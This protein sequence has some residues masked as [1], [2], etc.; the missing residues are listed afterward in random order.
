MQALKIN[1]NKTKF[2]VFSRDKYENTQLTINNTPV[3]RVSRFKY[4][5][6]LITNNMD[7]DIEIK[8]RIETARTA[9]GTMRAFLCND[10]LNLKL[11]QR[12]VKCYIWSVLLYGMESWTLIIRS[13]NRL[14]AFEMWNYR[15][16][17]R[18][19]W[20]DLLTNEEVLRRAN[21][22]RALITTIKC[23]K[24]AYL[25][26]ILRGEKYYLLQL[27]IKGKIEGRHRIG[28]RQMS[29]MRNI[30]EWTGIQRAG[31]LF[32]LAEDRETLSIVIANVR[33][34]G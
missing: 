10:N 15:R 6:S 20:T 4:L 22:D 21:T 3:E 25:G 34:T 8:C 33:G 2:M 28:R 23:R 18:I 7:P 16:M 1:V 24:I 13:L 12:M 27:I 11:K 26:H 14:E 30:R 19:P 31:N 9:F 17:L 32:R 29:W 5:G